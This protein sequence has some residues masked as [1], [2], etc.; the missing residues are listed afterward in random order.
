MSIKK[1]NRISLFEAAGSTNDEKMAQVEQVLRNMQAAH[2]V[3]LLLTGPTGIGKTTFVK[4][5]GRL[6]GMN[7]VVVEAPHVT[8]EHLINIPFMVKPPNK[9][10]QQKNIKTDDEESQADFDIKLAKSYLASELGN[11]KVITDKELLDLINNSNQNVKNSWAYFGG[12]PNSLPPIFKNIRSKYSVILFLDEYFRQ[13]SKNVRNM[14]RNILNGRLGNDIMPD[15][16][17]TMYATN[18]NDTEGSIEDIPK[19]NDFL[20]MSFRPPTKNEW[21]EYLKNEFNNNPEHPGV[22]LKPNVVK[23]FQDSLA[24]SDISF[25]DAD[26][27]LRTSPR[28]WEQIILYVNAALPAKNMQDARALLSAV[29]SNFQ[30]G[31]KTSSMYPKVLKIVQKLIAETNPALGNEATP[32]PESDWRHTLLHELRIKKML[33]DSRSYIPVI[34]G[35]PGIGKTAFAISVAEQLDMELIPIDCSALS[36]DEL[37][38]I[39]I[40]KT[41][42]KNDGGNDLTTKFAKPSLFIRILDDMAIADYEFKKFLKKEVADGKISASDATKKQEDYDTAPFKYVLFFDE[43]TRVNSP[44]VYNSLRRVILE[45]EFGDEYKIPDTCIIIAAM[46]PFDVGVQEITGHLKD[47]ISII[48]AKANWSDFSSHATDNEFKK[49]KNNV[50]KEKIQEAWRLVSTFADSYKSG[51]N[52]KEGINKDNRQ[53]FIKYTGNKGE[54]QGLS[55]NFYFSPREYTTLFHET[56]LALQQAND[57][58]LRQYKKY[59]NKETALAFYRER[60]AKLLIETFKSSLNWVIEH[61]FGIVSPQF[62]ADVNHWLMA[63]ANRMEMSF[64][65]LPKGQPIG[66]VVVKDLPKLKPIMDA[67][68]KNTNLH[69]KTIPEFQNIVTTFANNDFGEQLLEYLI[70]LALNQLKN[71]NGHIKDIIMPNSSYKIKGVNS[72]ILEYILNE[73]AMVD[74]DSTFMDEVVDTFKKFLNANFDR[75]FRAL[76]RNAGISPLNDDE[77]AAYR[78][79]MARLLNYGS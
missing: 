61:K 37:T 17:Y 7:V 31:D 10:G 22:K 57:D 8:E 35:E 26:S 40:P 47:S 2:P 3:R 67:V 43:L 9:A 32:L 29:R 28:R 71:P 13:T 1:T 42:N 46:N 41:V 21:F 16:V 19:N 70:N 65:D 74:A 25:D 38:G 23:A 76:I 15:N 60:C 24:D 49:L 59:N 12:T 73:L 56:A 79:L 75:G 64:K 77:N 52:E 54:K 68:L 55:S 78:K 39:P 18:L 4:N 58:A 50:S 48:S 36:V 30:Y 44:A 27:E 20:Q 34:Q 62:F 33:G 11:S 6:L 51:V 63:E 45:K 72:S 69:L 5:I 53:F 14:L 66:N